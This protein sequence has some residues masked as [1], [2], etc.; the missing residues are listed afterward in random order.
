M[1]RQNV[2]LLS[3]IAVLGVCIPILISSERG[4]VFVRHL[5]AHHIKETVIISAGHRRLAGLFDGLSPDPR[6]DV[7]RAL[8]MG[9]QKG[10][11]DQKIGL[12][13][14]LV[15]LVEGTAHAQSGCVTTPCNSCYMDVTSGMCQWANCT[16]ISWNVTGDNV[17]S[18]AQQLASYGCLGDSCN[19]A[20]NSGSCDN[21]FNCGC[22]GG[23]GGGGG[24][25]GP[26]FPCSDSGDPACCDGNHCNGGTCWPDY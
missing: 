10:C 25:S 24:C 18:G 17:C 21:S 3:I 15:A 8:Q 12:V 19:W 6:W 7:T 22:T 1:N 11:G 2:A 9:A 16:T 14:R 20:C 23:G 4:T 5:R 13:S 26:G